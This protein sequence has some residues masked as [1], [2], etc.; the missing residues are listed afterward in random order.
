MKTWMGRLVAG[1]GT[2]A[3]VAGVSVYEQ[4]SVHAATATSTFAVSSSVA[5]NCTISSNPLSFGPY[6]PVVA[7]ATTNLDVNTT[8]SVACTKGS[9]SA[10]SLDLGTHSA[11]AVRKMQNTVTATE[12]L[13]Y[14]LYTA[15]ARLVVWNTTNTVSYTSTGKAAST[16]TVYGRVPSGQDVAVG[17]YTD[18]VVAT[19]TF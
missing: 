8:L 4:S 17:S 13:N 1:V 19:I 16:L 2:A 14:E 6:D 3:L 18:S 5:A 11:A 9:T 15:A 10:V 7:N 12:L